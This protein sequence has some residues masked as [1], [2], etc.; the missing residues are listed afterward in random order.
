[1]LFRL[2]ARYR[3]ACREQ[4]VRAQPF[5]EERTRPAQVTAVLDVEP[6]RNLDLHDE[7]EL[8]YGMPARQPGP[9][10]LLWAIRREQHKE[11]DDA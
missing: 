11:A 4:A 1:V 10:R 5:L 6:G 9:E 2:A 7:C 8:I 3:R